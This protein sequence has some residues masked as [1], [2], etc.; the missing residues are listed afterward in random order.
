MPTKQNIINYLKELKPILEK[1]GIVLLGLFGSFAKDE[2][3]QNSDIDIMYETTDKFI[4]KFRGWD[5]F[6]YLQEN[7]REKV[8]NKFH[9][10]VDLFDK[11]SNSSIKEK[12]IKEVIYVYRERVREVISYFRKILKENQNAKHYKS[13]KSH[14]LYFSVNSRYSC[15]LSLR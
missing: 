7:L 2:N 8:A 14:S 1:E 10:K 15:N 6:T 13:K 5:A 4:Q 11:N 12:V 9:S 3:S